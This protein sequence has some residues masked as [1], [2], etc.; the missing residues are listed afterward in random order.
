MG[1]EDVLKMILF[2]TTAGASIVGFKVIKENNILMPKNIIE[3]RQASEEIFEKAPDAI[4][5]IWTENIQPTAQE[6]TQWF[7][8]NVVP[9]VQ[10]FLKEKIQPKIEKEIEKQEAAIKE[11]VEQE[12]NKIKVQIPK[13]LGELEDILA[14]EKK[15]ELICE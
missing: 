6:M 8:A 7:G 5:D 11:K 12:S 3:V 14:G 1:I 2:L 10:D 4:D 13:T 15:C 9:E